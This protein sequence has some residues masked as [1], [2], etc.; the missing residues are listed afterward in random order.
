MAGCT[1]GAGMRWR[2]LTF[3]E[4]ELYL[5]EVEDLA[6]AI[7]LHKPQRVT[8]ADSRTNIATILA[9]LQSARENRP[10]TLP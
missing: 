5:G 6:D 9:L 8:L 10:V 3:P 7:L 1:S 2:C 4:P